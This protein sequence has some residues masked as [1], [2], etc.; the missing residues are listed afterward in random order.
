M[1]YHKAALHKNST[2]FLLK[3]SNKREK[4]IGP[5]ASH[6]NYTPLTFQLGEDGNLYEIREVENTCFHRYRRICYCNIAIQQVENNG[7]CHQI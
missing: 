6:N 1:D 7:Q 5:I 4:A 2:H 3:P